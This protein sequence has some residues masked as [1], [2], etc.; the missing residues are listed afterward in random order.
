MHINAINMVI[1]FCSGNG[2]KKVLRNDVCINESLDKCLQMGNIQPEVYSSER[3]T[4][5]DLLQTTGIDAN[6]TWD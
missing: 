2:R 4:S 3:M 6:L 1:F 5:Y